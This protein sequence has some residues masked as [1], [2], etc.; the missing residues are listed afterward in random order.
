MKYIT[1][2]L[3]KYDFTLLFFLTILIFA[4]IDHV[5]SCHLKCVY[6]VRGV[7]K[8]TSRKQAI[9]DKVFL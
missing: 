6:N 1:T 3:T 2:R 7:C 5:V 4:I 8:M 9:S